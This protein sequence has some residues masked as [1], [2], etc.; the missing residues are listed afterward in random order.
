MTARLGRRRSGSRSTAAASRPERDDPRVARTKEAVLRATTELLAEQGLA[1]TSVEAV[2]ARSRVAKT[3][4]YRHWPDR[5]ALVLD[6]VNQL[7]ATYDVIDTGNLRADLLASVTELA[8]RLDR[9]PYGRVLPSLVD[10]ADRD[11]DLAAAFQR[12]GE[13]RR[14]SF[15]DRLELAVKRGELPAGTSVGVVHD[16]IVGP[17]F[18][19]RLVA[20]KPLR[21]ADLA[22]IVDHAIA[23]ARTAITRS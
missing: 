2:A 15:I 5:A 1:A 3:T 10:A 21:R 9:T 14:R 8:H 6:G 7:A 17:V 18:Y 16:L 19:R 11:A 20:R 4:I 13:S 22:V 12:H 23:G